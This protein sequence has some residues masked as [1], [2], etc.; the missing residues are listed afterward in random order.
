MAFTV[1]MKY[2]EGQRDSGLASMS[3]NVGVLHRQDACVESY[4]VQH[5]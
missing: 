3:H 4:T 5:R 2:T 1:L